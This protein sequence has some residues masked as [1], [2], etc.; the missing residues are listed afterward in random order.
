MSATQRHH[1]TPLKGKRALPAC[2]IPAFWL[3]SC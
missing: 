3:D 2:S 1:N